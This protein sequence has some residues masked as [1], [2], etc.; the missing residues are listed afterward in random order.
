MQVSAAYRAGGKPDNR[1]G[2]LLYLWLLYIVE[3]YVTHAVK[4]DR[5]Q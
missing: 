4:N 5:F 2:R 1:I 3:P